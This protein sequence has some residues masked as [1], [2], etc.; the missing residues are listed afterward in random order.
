MKSVVVH[1]VL[2]LAGLAFAYQ[3]WTREEEEERPEGEVTVLQCKPEELAKL[4][5]ETPTSTVTVVPR[6]EGDTQTYWVT[7]QRK[8]DEKKDEKKGEETDAAKSEAKNDKAPEPADAKAADPKP[9]AASDANAA[10]AETKDAAKAGEGKAAEEAAP[11]PPVDESLYAPK[12]FVA[13]PKF[14]DYLA[15]VTPLRVARGLGEIPSSKFEEFGFDK[16]GTF[17]L[18]ECGGKKIQL[19]VGGRTFGAGMQYL[20]DPATKQAYLA[21]AGAIHDLEAAQFK[22]M[23]VELHDFALADIDEAVVRAQG[24]ER[25]LLHRNRQ[26]ASEARW[27]DKAEPDRRNETFGN[28][29]GRLER[30][31][32]TSYL[33]PNAEPGSDL[34]QSGQVTPAVTVEYYTDGKPK[35]RLELVRVE[36][37]GKGT[38]YARTEATHVWTRVYDSIGKQVED[39]AA[40]VVG[41]EQPQDASVS[42]PAPP[43]GA[44]GVP[45]A[46]TALPAAPIAPHGVPRAAPPTTAAPAKPAAPAARPPAVK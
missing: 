44:S 21:E 45:G 17:F 29:F 24:T 36:A 33:E 5:L 35:G 2:A 22:F 7:T 8:R 6:K 11:K 16:V 12:R 38:Y 15:K 9:G 10:K 27:V 30:L 46:G 3:T 4:S 32:V 20:R 1:A 14:K 13:N 41:V 43:P 28:W 31:R 37:E 18:V 42:P 39:D 40:L 25:R 34:K 23:Q 26:V 19:D